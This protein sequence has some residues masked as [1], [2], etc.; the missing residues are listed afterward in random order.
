MVPN[1]PPNLQKTEEKLKNPQEPNTRV[2]ES[3]EGLKHSTNATSNALQPRVCVESQEGLKHDKA[4]PRDYI[5]RLWVQVESQEGLK[6]QLDAVGIPL[7]Y[8]Y[9]LS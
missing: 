1:R 4:I 9:L 3:Q 8:V 6:R 2:V 5:N 7:A